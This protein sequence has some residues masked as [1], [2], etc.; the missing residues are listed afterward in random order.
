MRLSMLR[1][2]RSMV[3][4]MSSGMTIASSG[5]RAALRE[6]GTSGS[7]I[8]TAGVRGTTRGERVKAMSPLSPPLRAPGID[9][10]V[11]SMDRRSVVSPT[12]TRSLGPRDR[13]WTR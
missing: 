5:N 2:I 11:V 13:R 6:R 8:L 1:V 4:P 10:T 7:L 9:E 12:V 3:A